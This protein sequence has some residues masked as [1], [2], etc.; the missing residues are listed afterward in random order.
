MEG[1]NQISELLPKLMRAVGSIS[2]D[3]RNEF[4]NYTFRGIDDVLNHVGPPCAELDIRVSPTVHDYQSA[5]T[6]WQETG[7]HKFQVRVT[8]RLRLEFTAPDGSTHVAEGIGEAIDTNGD[9]ASNKAMSAA[10]KY[11]CFMGLVIPVSGALDDSD[12]DDK[13]PAPKTPPRPPAAPKKATPSPKAAPDGTTATPD[14]RARFLKLLKPVSDE[15]CVFFGVDSL[16]QLADM[17]FPSTEREADEIMDGI[18][19]LV[20]EGEQPKESGWRAFPLPF[21]KKKGQT[22]GD[23]AHEDGKYLFGLAMNFEVETEWNGKPKRK[24]TIEKDQALRRALD[25]CK[26]ELFDQ[27]AQ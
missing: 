22:L 15:A 18:R 20:D 13:V 5:V 6:E 1:M 11:A 8:L 17:D 3:R 9:K 2:K 24:E 16:D 14:Q 7:K 23:I 25:E 10:F 4:Q 21:G 26:A 12:D 19:K 27:P